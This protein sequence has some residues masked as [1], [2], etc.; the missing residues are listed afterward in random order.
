MTL[1]HTWFKC[2]SN[3]PEM[4]RNN[5]QNS[6]IDYES[7]RFF[8]ISTGLYLDLF[9]DAVGLKNPIEDNVGIQSQVLAEDGVDA[10]ERGPEVFRNEV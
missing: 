7:M 5:G 8:W 10:G 1:N 4:L 3:T 6:K 2:G 9:S